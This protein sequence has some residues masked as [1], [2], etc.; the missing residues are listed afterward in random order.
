M[1]PADHHHTPFCL[2][3]LSCSGTSALTRPVTVPPVRGAPLPVASEDQAA[4]A[5]I[6][7]LAALTIELERAFGIP[8]QYDASDPDAALLSD[9]A[10]F[11]T[12]EEVPADVDME[13][14][15][16]ARMRRGA[17]ADRIL[18]APATTAFGRRCK[19]T[20][21]RVLLHEGLI[22][23]LVFEAAALVDDSELL[24]APPRT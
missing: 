19:A 13:V 7:R 15:F 22:C 20:V 17:L 18:A 9:C 21:A 6:E 11:L 16:T 1:S 10:E 24:F 14:F 12:A 3:A 4:A 8:D 5:V 23:A 2:A